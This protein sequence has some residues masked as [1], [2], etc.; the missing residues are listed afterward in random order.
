MSEYLD[1]LRAKVEEEYAVVHPAIAADQDEDDTEDPDDDGAVA[2]DEDDEEEV[3]PPAKADADEDGLEPVAPAGKKR[4][5][6]TRT[7]D[8]KD[9]SEPQVFSART[10]DELTDKIVEAQVNASRRINELKK[11]QRRNIA[12][13]S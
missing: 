12:A 4:T 7:I 11:Q 6:F 10:R 8:L 5:N 9:G 2:G 3:I 1:K 13:A